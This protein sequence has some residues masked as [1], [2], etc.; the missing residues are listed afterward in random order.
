MSYKIE[1]AKKAIKQINSLPYFIIKNVSKRIDKLAEN[2]FPYD[3]KKL[4]AN[5]N[6]YRIRVGNYR[7]LYEVFKQ[8]LIIKIVRVAHRKDAYKV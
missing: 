7:I 8:N 1:I 4:K 5:E 6:A 3:S 2:P